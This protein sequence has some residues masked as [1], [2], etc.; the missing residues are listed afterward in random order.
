MSIKDFLN[1]LG[2]RKQTVVSILLV[3]L[4]LTVLLIAIQPFKYG[5]T[6]RLLVSQKFTAGTDAYTISQSNN[7]LSKLFARVVQ[8]ESFYNDI[9]S[10]GYSIDESYFTEEGSRKEK[11]KKWNKTVKSSSP[12][13]GN[14]IVEIKVYH[15]DQGQVEQIAQAVNYV[16][17]TQNREYHGLGDKIFLKVIDRPL[18]SEKPER[19]DVLMI[20]PISVLLAL[21]L[22]GV[23]IYFFPEDKYDIKI[24]PEKG[25]GEKKTALEN[26]IAQERKRKIWQDLNSKFSQKTGKKKNE[27]TF[28]INKELK[29]NE[30]KSNREV[31][32]GEEKAKEKV[33]FGGQIER[34][35]PE[36]RKREE[37]QTE[38]LEKISEQKEEDVNKREDKR[39]IEE[40]GDM[41]NIFG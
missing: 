14:G 9:I 36:S 17:K 23:Y 26:W 25:A 29:R 16:L 20:F 8:S 30:Q 1:L 31:V 11:M 37:E 22:A 15:S 6:S 39:D 12:N 38:S 41:N 27:K 5:S 34:E 13:T 21:F 32:S 19:P 4:A 28:S 40:K 24:I 18:V 3:C 10:S 35:A 33:L 7:F 2:K